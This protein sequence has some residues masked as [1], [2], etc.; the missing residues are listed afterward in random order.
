MLEGDTK[1]KSQMEIDLQGFCTDSHLTIYQRVDGGDDNDQGP[2]SST[3]HIH[4]SLSRSLGMRVPRCALPIFLALIVQAQEHTINSVD[5]PVAVRGGS[6]YSFEWEITGNLSMKETRTNVD[7]VLGRNFSSNGNIVDVIRACSAIIA[8]TVVTVFF[9]RVQRV[10]SQQGQSG[11]IQLSFAKLA[12]T[13]QSPFRHLPRPDYHHDHTIHRDDK[14]RTQSEYYY[15]PLWYPRDHPHT[16]RYV[17]RQREHREGILHRWP[18]TSRVHSRQLSSVEQLHVA[19]HHISA[20]RGRYPS[21][22]GPQI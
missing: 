2:S 13:D 11:W 18:N 7:L 6:R 17:Q 8:V 1:F 20:A 14:P 9:N 4:G 12:C 16:H 19:S 5:G 21:C 10:K 15:P 22:R 3:P